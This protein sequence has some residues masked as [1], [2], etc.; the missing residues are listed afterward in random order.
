MKMTSAPSASGAVDEGAI[1]LQDRLGALVVAMVTG[2][3]IGDG[4]VVR[5]L[6]LLGLPAQH[7]AD[8]AVVPDGDVLASLPQ[9]PASERN[10]R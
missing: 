10:R 7:F 1:L 2:N 8:E 9:S 3:E 6:E 5:H 4:R